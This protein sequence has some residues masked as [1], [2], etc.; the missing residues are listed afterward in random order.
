MIRKFG[1]FESFVI[2]HV[3][4][5]GEWR[6]EMEWWEKFGNSIKVLPTFHN[7][8]LIKCWLGF[9]LNRWQLW[10]YV[11]RLGGLSIWQQIKFPLQTRARDELKAIGNS[12][13]TSTSRERNAGKKEKKYALN[14]NLLSS[15]F[16]RMFSVLFYLCCAIYDFQ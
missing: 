11:I 10:I 5:D 14:L 3:D 9:V 8:D 13:K 15:I 16:L 7:E 12:N 1:K 4:F 6:K 2:H